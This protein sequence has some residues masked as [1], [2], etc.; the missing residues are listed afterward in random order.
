MLWESPFSREE[1][2]SLSVVR[3]AEGYILHQLAVLEQSDPCC[4]GQWDSL[5]RVWMCWEIE[6]KECLSSCGMLRSVTCCQLQAGWRAA[7]LTMCLGPCLSRTVIS[8]L[9]QVLQNSVCASVNLQSL[10]QEHLGGE[11]VQ[12]RDTEFRCRCPP[13]LSSGMTSPFSSSSLMGLEV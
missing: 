9:C 12:T 1:I 2:T 11:I 10:R 13:C 8:S 4:L 6:E 7:V 3:E 5:D